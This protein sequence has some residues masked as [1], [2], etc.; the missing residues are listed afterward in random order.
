MLYRLSLDTLFVTNSEERK[1][2]KT[3]AFTFTRTESDNHVAKLRTSLYRTMYAMGIPQ[4]N[5]GLAFVLRV[6]I[7][8]DVHLE[9]VGGKEH[10]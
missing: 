5:S 9:N 1:F 4:V 6:R 10:R 8:I 3:Y 7:K 2:A